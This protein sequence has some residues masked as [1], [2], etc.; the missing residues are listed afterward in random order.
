LNTPSGPPRGWRGLTSEKPL[1]AEAYDEEIRHEAGMP[2][3][4]VR[5]RMNL[6]HGRA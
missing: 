5:E 4:A 3:V 2:S 1:S 6:H